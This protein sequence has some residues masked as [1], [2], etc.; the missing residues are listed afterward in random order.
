MRPIW[1]AITAEPEFA[2]RATAATLDAARGHAR[3]VEAR[4]GADAPAAV[5]EAWHALWTAWTG[6]VGRAVGRARAALGSGTPGTVRFPAADDE[7]WAALLALLPWVTVDLVGDAQAEIGRVSE[8]GRACVA[9]LT[10]E[11]GA[12]L[13]ER[14]AAGAEE[15]SG[16]TVEQLGANRTWYDLGGTS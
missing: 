2:A 4:L 16:V 13:R 1:F 3:R 7:A 11:E 8:G 12:A 5:Q 10:A 9:R 15:G 14:L 6:P